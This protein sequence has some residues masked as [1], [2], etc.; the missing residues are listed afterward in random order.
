MRR[1]TRRGATR[2]GASAGY[3]FVDRGLGAVGGL[4]ACA[5][6]AS[7]LSDR[8]VARGFAVRQG[9]GCAGRI[10][11]KG[12][13][14]RGRLRRTCR[15]TGDPT[16]PPD[17]WGRRSP[18]LGTP[19]ASSPNGR[20]ALR[21]AAFARPHVP[22]RSPSPQRLG[23]SAPGRGVEGGR[24]RGAS[25]RHPSRCSSGGLAPGTSAHGEAPWGPRGCGI[26]WDGVERRCRG[27]LRPDRGKKSGL[28]CRRLRESA[29]YLRALVGVAQ[30]VE[31]QVVA[32]VVA[33][34]T[35]VTHPTFLLL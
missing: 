5:W 26:G 35:P 10:K 25:M 3:A 16:G 11:G 8:G 22:P 33:G 28:G 12:G 2:R 13:R 34:S 18:A 20:G 17:R 27:G 7:F 32:L 24:I 1:A 23:R 19:L 4:W 14:A 15:Q 29:V 31:H 9:R 21:D 30:S 6:T